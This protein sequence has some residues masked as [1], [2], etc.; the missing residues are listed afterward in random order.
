MGETPRPVGGV[1]SGKINGR[2]SLCGWG[3][4]CGELEM[5][6]WPHRVGLQL[7]VR[8]VLCDIS[9]HH[10]A[11]GPQNEFGGLLRAR[12]SSNEAGSGRTYSVVIA[13]GGIMGC[14][15]AYFLAQRIP[16][17]SICVVERDSKVYGGVVW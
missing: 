1:A 4:L 9:T 6:L 13:G 2:C 5:R 16:P 14:S 15:S 17:S 11:V 3:Y 12:Q 10:R 7:P 8:R